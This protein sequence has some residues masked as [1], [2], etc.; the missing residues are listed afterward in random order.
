MPN[1]FFP[2]SVL[3]DVRAP[4]QTTAKCGKCGLYK[5]C[6]S[7]KM[8]PTGRGKRDVLVVG[9]APGEREDEVG[10]QFVG[11]TGKILRDALVTVGLNP[12]RDCV[13]DNALRCR[14]PNNRI[15]D[16]RAVEYCRPNVLNTIKAHDP[17]VIVL[18]GGKAVRSVIGHLWK[19]DVGPVKRWAGWKIPSQ[20]WNTWICPTFHPSF[21]SRENSVV[22]SRMFLKHVGA[23]AE[24]HADRPWDKI[25]NY[26][27][28]VEVVFDHKEAAEFI[29]RLSVGS[30]AVAF[31]Y[32][33]NMLKPES[34]RA[35]IVCCAVSDGKRT[36]AYPWVGEA[37]KA[38]KELLRSR[39]PKIASNMKFEERWTLK[40]FGVGVRNWR[41]DT[42]LASH[43][44]DHRELITSIKFQS[45]VRLGQTSYD[46]HIKP[47][48]K[49]K[50]P[51]GYA[52]NRIRD[53]DMTDL[54]LYCGL[55][56]LLEW[57]VAKIQKKELDQA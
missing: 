55:D 47:Y 12:D 42:M 9:E 4:D 18:L 8:E 38:T 2:L 10:R 48:L 50:L 33:T 1:T 25:P 44:L 24:L 26:R 49:S 52:I 5:T 37:V 30:R 20:K 53:A 39:V 16:D 51:G 43:V 45:F 27:K 40:H 46:D 54:M 32:E 57:Q 22:L 56:A 23:A 35:V 3:Q 28:E 15:K 14:P 31:D 29:R 17:K 34:E 36:V 6:N 19:E 41:L 11:K 13:F 7:P 21:V